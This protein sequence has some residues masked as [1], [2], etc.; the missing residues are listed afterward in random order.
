M[1]NMTI[2]MNMKI[3]MRMIHIMNMMNMINKLCYERAENEYKLNHCEH[4]ETD[5]NINTMTLMKMMQTLENRR[6]S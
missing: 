1:Q 6:A 3:K 2:M 5:V 4:D